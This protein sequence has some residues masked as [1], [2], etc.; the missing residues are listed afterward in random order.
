MAM[1]FEIQTVYSGAQ[2]YAMIPVIA[3]LKQEVSRRIRLP[4]IAHRCHFDF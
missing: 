3:Q 2:Q 4:K 1:L